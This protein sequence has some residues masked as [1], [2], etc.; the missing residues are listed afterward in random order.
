ML[1]G[2]S[3]RLRVLKTL[4]RVLL[5]RLDN[6]LFHRTHVLPIDQHCM[7]PRILRQ[8]TARRRCLDRLRLLVGEQVIHRRPQRIDVRPGVCLHQLA[9][10]L[11]RTALSR[12]CNRPQVFRRGVRDRP[13]VLR[14][15]LFLRVPAP[16][17]T[18]IDQEHIVLIRHHDIARL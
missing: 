14:V 12:P 5:H 10:I 13:Q 15:G 7:Q 3:H 6:H 1:Q 8:N 18:E 2:N 17:D 9:R 16:R 4:R 11:R